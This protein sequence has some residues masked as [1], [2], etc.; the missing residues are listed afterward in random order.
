MYQHF[1]K[2]YLPLKMSIQKAHAYRHDIAGYLST[3]FF[4]LEIAAFCSLSFLLYTVL[5]KIIAL[6]CRFT[7]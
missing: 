4:F 6:I 3:Y 2:T 7:V 1:S 5:S